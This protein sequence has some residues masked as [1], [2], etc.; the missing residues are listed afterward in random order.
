MQ[1]YKDSLKLSD[2]KI[3]FTNLESII[4][5]RC[6]EVQDN[7]FIQNEGNITCLLFGEE[8]REAK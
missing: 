6:D 7:S 3:D 5:R 4:L 1:G 8:I 2:L